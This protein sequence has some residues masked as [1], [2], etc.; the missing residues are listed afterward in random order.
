VAYIKKSRA[1]GSFTFM[2]GYMAQQEYDLVDQDEAFDV[3]DLEYLLHMAT[4]EIE[5]RMVPAGIY[6]DGSNTP[7]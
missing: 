5:P 3:E 4:E 1:N 6:P 7:C 2:G